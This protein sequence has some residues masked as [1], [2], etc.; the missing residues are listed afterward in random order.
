MKILKL[1]IYTVTVILFFTQ[2]T[3]KNEIS[4]W[5]GP[6]RDGIYL[7]NNLLDKWPENGPELLWRYDELGIG[8][9]TASVT[10][11]RVYTVGTID[12]ISYIFA[13]DLNGNLVWK[14][15]LG[16]E[17]MSKFP[18]AHG[19]PLIYND[20]G[21]FLNGLGKLFCFNINNGDIIWTKDLFHEFD[22]INNLY[23][24][25]ENLLIDNEKLFC[26][27]GG[28]E[29]NVVALNRMNGDLI[30]K[31]SGCGEISSYNS[32]IIIND[33]GQKFLTLITINSV[34]S[35]NIANG[36]LAW[37]YTLGTDTMDWISHP[38]VPIYNDGYLFIKSDMK[39]G[40]VML[41]IT[42]NGYKA[43]EIWKNGDL[44][45]CI[46]DAVLLNDKLYSV[47]GRKLYAVEWKTGN[48]LYEDSKYKLGSIISANGLLYCLGYNGEFSLIRPT[49]N[50]FELISSFQVSE[51]K[52]DYWG[53]PVIKNGRLYVRHNNSLF[54]Y[55]IART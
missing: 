13:L 17:W 53:Q 32:P 12:S 11:N 50:N 48:I 23:S 7:E 4:Q 6:N 41:K 55:N 27:P 20:L 40:S 21:Y 34:F 25:T 52:N 42:D 49:E 5:R 14:K 22:G 31:S 29:A 46:G 19:T 33:F 45:N 38:N 2:C 54:V 3:K 35:I 10:S 16:P 43:T 1:T 51:K 47:G 18:G 39:I 26:I 15:E 36:E 37:E 30:W 28:K 44:M 24:I 9:S 8:Y